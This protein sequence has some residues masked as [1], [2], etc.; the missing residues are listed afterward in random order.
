ML[1]S[2]TVAKGVTDTHGRVARS[3]GCGGVCVG[4]RVCR[5]E[6]V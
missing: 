5:W 1:D 2:V 3:L 4:G 6:G